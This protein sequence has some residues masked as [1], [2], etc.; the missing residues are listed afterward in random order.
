MKPNKIRHFTSNH[1]KDEDLVCKMLDWEEKYA[2]GVGQKH[3]KECSLD[4]IDALCS[5]HPE[6]EIAREVLRNFGFSDDVFSIVQ[7]RSIFS[8][9]YKSPRD[10]N[11][12]VIKSSYYMRNNRSQFYLTEKVSIGSKLKDVIVS[13]LCGNDLNIRD[14]HK[15]YSIVLYQ[16]FS[17][18]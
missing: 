1:V 18:S 14:I 17:V 13:D 15:K 6:D 7:F 4:G 9:Y 5:L 8:H 16:P 2:F 10:Y 12:R 3:Y 11:E